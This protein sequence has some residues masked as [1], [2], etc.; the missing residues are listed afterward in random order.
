[1][2]FSGIYFELNLPIK[3]EDWE[4]I[5]GILHHKSSKPSLL[6]QITIIH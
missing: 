4:D 6:V 1:M 2:L 5:Y 3:Q